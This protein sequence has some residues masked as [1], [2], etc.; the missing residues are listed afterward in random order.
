MANNIFQFLLFLRCFNVCICFRLCHYHKR[1]FFALCVVR[2]GE[3][4]GG[5]C[6]TFL[7]FV[8]SSKT[9]KLHWNIREVYIDVA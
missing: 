6:I 2:V 5:H 7:D 1:T 9:S 3:E 4:G 8:N